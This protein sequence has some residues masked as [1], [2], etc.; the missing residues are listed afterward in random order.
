MQTRFLTGSAF[1]LGFSCVSRFL[2]DSSYGLSIKRFLLKMRLGQR[3]ELVLIVL[4]HSLG[5]FLSWA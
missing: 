4:E 3:L 1:L 2:Q 5:G